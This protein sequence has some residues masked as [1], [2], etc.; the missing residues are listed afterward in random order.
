VP[1][2]MPEGV[3]YEG[4]FG[5]GRGQ[6]SGMGGGMGGMMMR[7]RAVAAPPGLKARGGIRMMN[8]I[9]VFSADLELSERG[10]RSRPAQA[11]ALEKQLGEMEKAG[12]PEA[13]RKPIL[14]QLL[15]IKLAPEL[16]GLAEKVAKQGTNG[17]LTIG[18]LKVTAGR[19]EIRLQ[20]ASLDDALLEKLKELGFKELARAKSVK[21]LI[22][23]IDVEKL[24]ALAKLAAVRHIDPAA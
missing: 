11:E 8:R 12:K 24:E 4:V 9:P 7:S 1:V 14:E 17:N 21:L 10:A 2:E 6:G 15:N 13:E 22:G 5:S 16:R 3:S 18:K 20:L 23:T 19:V